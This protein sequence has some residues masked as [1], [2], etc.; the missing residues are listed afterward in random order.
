[1]DYNTIAKGYDWLKGNPNRPTRDIDMIFPFAGMQLPPRVSVHT[2]HSDLG[3]SGF[4]LKKISIN[5]FFPNSVRPNSK[6][7]L[8]AYPDIEADVLHNYIDSIVA[9]PD[10]D[11]TVVRRSEPNQIEFIPN[12]NIVTND[13]GFLRAYILEYRGFLKQDNDFI[14]YK[15]VIDNLIDE[16]RNTES[17]VPHLQV[18]AHIAGN[19]RLIRY[20]IMRYDECMETSALAENFDRAI[21]FRERKKHLQDILDTTPITS[22]ERSC[23]DIQ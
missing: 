21:L 23:S 12:G 17:D 10:D 7:V 1:M 20:T 19:P 22:L 15:P 5:Y 18:L 16:M 9:N 13:Q 6:T 3:Y 14:D 2:S 4:V 11:L 8:F